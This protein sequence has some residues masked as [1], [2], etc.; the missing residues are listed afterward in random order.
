MIIEKPFRRDASQPATVWRSNHRREPAASRQHLRHS[1]VV[2]NV[3]STLAIEAAIFD[4]PVVNIVVRRRDAGASGCEV[5]APLLPFHALRQHHAA[6]GGARGGDARAARRAGRALSRRS[7]ARSR[8]PAPRRCRAVSVHRRS[9]GRA[10]GAIRPRR[11]RRRH[12]NPRAMCGIAG[13]VSLT[14]RPAERARVAAMIATLRHRGPDDTGVAIDGPAALSAARL[15]IIDVAGGHQPIGIDGGI[16]VAQNGE[17]YNYV[18]LRAELERAGRV[19]ENVERHRSDRASLRRAWPVRVCADARHV[20]DCHL[21]RAEP[22]P[23]ARTRS[24]RQETALLHP[25][26]RRSAVWLGDE[27]S[28]CGARHHAVRKLRRSPELLHVRIRRRQSLGLRG[29][30]TTP[31]R[32]HA[33]RRPATAHGRGLAVL[34][35]AGAA[36]SGRNGRGRGDRTTSFRARRSGSYPPAVRRAARR[37]P[38]RRHGFGGRPGIDGQALVASGKDLHD[39]LRR[40]RPTT[41][42]T[43][44]ERPRGILAR[45]TTN[46]SSRPTA[47]RSPKHW[48]TTTTSRSPTRRRFQRFTSRRWRG[49]TSPSR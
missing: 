36:A 38:E 29:D 33:H 27:G 48:R 39:R 10:C 1:D 32:H 4:T 41:S 13:F 47:S 2:V 18:E 20:R 16:T 49:S 44:R 19:F 34:A 6:S 43:R 21:G 14:G 22:A 26:K 31:S 15:S 9:I 45:N 42:S 37:V 5:G 30:G 25:A 8:G 35:M 11:A 23:G 24:C 28:A 3:A 40:R 7:L 17:I 46:K 12:W